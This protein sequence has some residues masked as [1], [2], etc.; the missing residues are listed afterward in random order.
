MRRESTYE[1]RKGYFFNRRNGR[2]GKSGNSVGG[3]ILS[4]AAA[5]DDYENVF[6]TG[7]NGGAVQ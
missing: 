5:A 4:P 2:S 6:P 7:S 3:L 1:R